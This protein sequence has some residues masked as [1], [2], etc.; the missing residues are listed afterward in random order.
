[1]PTTLAYS[2]T[3]VV[4]P[5][6]CLNA[7]NAMEFQHQLKAVV[8]QAEQTIVLV[9]LAQVESLDSAGLMALVSGLKLAQQLERRFGICSVSPSVRIVFELTQLDQVF[10]IFESTAAFEAAIAYL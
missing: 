6:G 9:D 3:T 4:R 7:S 5:Q 1:M 2:K 8:A 10:E